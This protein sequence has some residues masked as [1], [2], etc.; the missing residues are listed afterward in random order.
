[1]ALKVSFEIFP[2]NK[3]VDAKKGGGVYGGESNRP[4]SIN[5]WNVEVGATTSMCDDGKPR[6]RRCYQDIKM[7]KDIDEHSVVLARMLI[8]NTPLRGVLHIFEPL[9]VNG[10]THEYATMVIEF[11]HTAGGVDHLNGYVTGMTLKVPDGGGRGGR[12]DSKAGTEARPPYEEITFTFNT[13]KF[14]K[15]SDD[16]QDSV[17]DEVEDS[18]SQ[19]LLL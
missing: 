7:R 9:L 8:T 13:I 1:M 17:A 16:G 19:G 10:R 2:E 18:V 12:G 15:K 14:T 4:V 3:S 11:G 5:C 6:D